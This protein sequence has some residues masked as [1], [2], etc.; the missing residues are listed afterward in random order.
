MLALNVTFQQN[1]FSDF[2]HKTWGRTDGWTEWGNRI[3]MDLFY[4]FLTRSLVDAI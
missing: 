3:D 1:S 2:G 4:S